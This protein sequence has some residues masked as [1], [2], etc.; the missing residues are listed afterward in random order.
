MGQSLQHFKISHNIVSYFET[1]TVGV[2]IKQTFILT[3][4]LDYKIYVN[5]RKYKGSE[6]LMLLSD[7]SFSLQNIFLPD[8]L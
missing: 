5:L 1:L 4:H 3:V 8:R 7:F 6:I 2:K